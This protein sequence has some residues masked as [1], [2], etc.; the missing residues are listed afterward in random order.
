MADARLK[1]VIDYR[2]ERGRVGPRVVEPYSL[3]RS[4]DGNLLLEKDPWQGLSLVEGVQTPS[5]APGLG[6]C[7]A[8]P[9]PR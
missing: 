1:V 3:R 7:K 2:P 8:D 9:D 4:L 5:D 6:V